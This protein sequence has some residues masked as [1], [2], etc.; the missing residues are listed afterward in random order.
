MNI[1]LTGAS[2]YLGGKVLKSLL[3]EGHSIIALA[4]NKNDSPKEAKNLKVYHLDCHRAETA[5]KENKIDGVFHFATCYGRRG[6]DF[7]SI[8]QT[9]IL[10]PLSLLALASENKSKFF[11]NTDTILNPKINPYA[12]SK[13]QFKQWLNFYSS[14]LKCINIR[15]DHFYGPF[16][17]P[18]KFIAWIIKN[19]KE[20]AEKIDL[21]KGDQKRDFIYID[22]LCAAYM[23]VFNKIDELPL[24]KIHNF[25]AGTGIKTSI[26][27]TVLLIKEFFPENKTKLNFGAVPYRQNEIMDYPLDNSSLKATGWK[28]KTILKE[29][30][31]TILKEEGII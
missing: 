6:E 4:P 25:E 19:L 29:G 10:L 21:T 8:A 1:L 27:D 23:S 24:G 15:I 14:K 9:N 12:L 17:K 22:D 16:D 28:A 31:K 11:I 2:G 20:N 7:A 13:S 26:K 3:E 30:I 18:I 5:F